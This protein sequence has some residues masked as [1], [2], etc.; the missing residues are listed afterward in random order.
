MTALGRIAFCTA[1]LLFSQSPSLAQ[2]SA[3]Q[4]GSVI[5]ARLAAGATQ[6]YSLRALELTLLSF[7]AEALDESLDPRLELLDSSGRLISANDDYDYPAS[8]DA[9]IQA[10][11]LPATGVYTLAVSAF[12]E[13]SG[14]Y[15]LHV[16]PGY[17]RLALRDSDMESSNWEVVH[18][19]A[20]VNLSESGRLAAGMRGVARSAALLGLR[21]PIER[22]SYFEVAFAS[23]N[24]EVVWQVGLV[25]RYLSPTQ[26]HR[27][28]LSSRGY[29]RVDRVDGDAVTSLRNWTTHPAI[30]P[31]E[32]DFRLGAHISGGRYDI[33]Y[34]GQIVGA[35]WDDAPAVAG[36]LGLAIRT[37][38][39]VGGSVS[40]FVREMLATLPTRVDGELIRP[41]RL[42]ARGAYATAE[43]LA[44]QQLTPAGGEV[45]ITLDESLVRRVRPG[46]SRLGVASELQFAQFA[47]A[48]TL[49]LEQ[50]TEGHG[51]CGLFFHYSGDEHYTLAYTTSAGE[52][53]L[54]RRDARG[55]APGVFGQRAPSDADRRHLLLIVQ[56]DEIRFYLDEAYAGSLP[57]QPLI[58]SVGVAAVNYEEADVTC[59]FSDLWL[60]SLDD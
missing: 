55:F 36:S 4:I 13:S 28:L 18:S 8:R 35:A 59:S 25:F 51:G 16:L 29:W 56:D 23:V 27:L 47:F 12:G 21:L 37:D 5:E 20:P 43:T 52:Y 39:S 54:S 19:N 33:V 50:R 48:A 15:R 9:A 2:D 22:D 44:R 31:G 6:R 38:E 57:N 14:A 1:L 49:R 40:F 10:F 42:L 58:G 34:N 32:S 41:G 45:K 60:L 30:R 24:S 17:D 11:V 7:R 3:L 26:Y 46:I 53:G